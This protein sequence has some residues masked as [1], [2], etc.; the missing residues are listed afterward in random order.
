MTLRMLD[1][2]T[3][4]YL[5]RAHP[6]V[7]RRVASA[8]ISTLCISSMVEAELRYGIARRPRATQMRHGMEQLLTRL[9]VLSWTS[10]TAKRFGKLRAELEGMGRPLSLFDTLIAA[11]ALEADAVLVTSDRS[12]GRVPGL[13]VEDWTQ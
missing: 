2:N 7:S 10:A 6:A 11:H 9:D 13:K 12:F 8:E 3:L 5:F 4:S 1:S